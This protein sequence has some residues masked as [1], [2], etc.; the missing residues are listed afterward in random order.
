MIKSKKDIFTILKDN[1]ERIKNFGVKRLGVFGSVVHGRQR[2][3]SD[4]DVLVEFEHEKK[5]FDNFIHLAFL[6]EKL[7]DRDVELITK[8]SLSPYLKPRVMGEVEYVI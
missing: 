5:T 3:E 1:Q 6:L 8:E 2:E 4:I 7:F